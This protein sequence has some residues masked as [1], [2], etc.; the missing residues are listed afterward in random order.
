M[1]NKMD[2]VR[3]IEFKKV[4]F[5][6]SSF[7]KFKKIESMIFKFHF[8]H[9][10]KKVENRTFWNFV[11]S[12]FL[13]FQKIESMILNFR[14]FHRCKKVENWKFRNFVFSRGDRKLKN[15]LNIYW[16]LI[17]DFILADSNNVKR[18]KKSLIPLTNKCL[19]VSFLTPLDQTVQ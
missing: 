18:S 5:L 8:F 2:I 13:K 3:K 14:F 6:N 17:L 4:D 19:E 12:T 1:V 7:L 10:Y 15:L 9:R 11:F 16:C